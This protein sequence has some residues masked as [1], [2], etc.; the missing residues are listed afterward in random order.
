MSCLGED[1]ASLI[2]DD[3]AEINHIAGWKL[4]ERCVPK[5]F[6]KCFSKYITYPPVA[7]DCVCDMIFLTVLCGELSPHRGDVEKVKPVIFECTNV[8]D[9]SSEAPNEHLL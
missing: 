1:L 6:Y 7:D 4:L 2:A 3:E 5:Y 9:A 8:N